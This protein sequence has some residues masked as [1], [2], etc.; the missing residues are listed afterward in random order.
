MHRME[1]AMS[2]TEALYLGLT[3]GA[4]LVFVMTV[5]FVDWRGR[6]RPRSPREQS[7]LDGVEEAD[8]AKHWLA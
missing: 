2:K 7:R 4:C 6:E 8:A 3:I 1:G 5:A